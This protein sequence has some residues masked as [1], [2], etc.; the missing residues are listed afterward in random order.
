VSNYGGGKGQQH[1]KL[2]PLKSEN[3]HTTV[4]TSDVEAAL[5][6]LQSTCPN[7]A[8]VA[9]VVAWFGSDLRAGHCRIE[10]GVDSTGIRQITPELA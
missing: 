5:D 6:D 8:R 3:R 7:L 2:K 9:I 10:P 4:A 1:T